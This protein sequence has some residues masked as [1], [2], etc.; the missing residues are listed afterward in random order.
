MEPLPSDQAPDAGLRPL[1]PGDHDELVELY[2]DAVLSQAAGLYSPDQIDAWAHHPG[3]SGAL[4][5]PLAEGFGLA[6]TAATPGSAGSTGSARSI[7]AFGLLHPV[8]R[9]ALLYCR[10]RACRQGRASAILGA[11]ER[12]ARDQG[13]R[14]LRT[15]ASQLSRP[16]LERRGWLV[17]A[18][19][20]VLF[21][22]AWFTRWRMI[23]R[24]DPIPPAEFRG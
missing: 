16:L 6:S 4:R 23:R 21:A 20:T 7:E 11:L 15:E 14:Q 8:D 13:Q 24:L 9:L 12:H 19:E 2:R 10:G 1:R 3:R 5:Q 22:G 17:E 18:E